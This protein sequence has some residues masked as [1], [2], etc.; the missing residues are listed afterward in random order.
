M[1]T[2]RLSFHATH[3]R[4]AAGTALLLTGVLFCA[5]TAALAQVYDLPLVGFKSASATV[6]RT[7]GT[8]DIIV[9]LSAAQTKTTITVQYAVTGGSAVSP[10][11]YTIPAGSSGT[12]TFPAGT[13]DQTIT[14][15]ITPNPVPHGDS[16]VV[17][18]LSNPINANLDINTFTLT[19]QDTIPT[20]ATV[21]FDYSPYEEVESNGVAWISVTMT[22][23]PTGPVS[24]NYSTSDGTANSDPKKGAVN[25][26]PASGT[27]TWAPTEAGTSKWFTIVLVDDGNVDLTLTVNLTLSSPVNASLGSPSTAVLN[28]LDADTICPP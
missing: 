20:S 24:V 17:L 21:A 16:T 5:P 4:I 13:T 11:D 23:T 9:S 6:K 14:V 26:L 22:G 12:L 19:I 1:R 10:Q 8:Y 3:A 18:S 28:I 2:L 25:Y 7:D 27:L 15:V